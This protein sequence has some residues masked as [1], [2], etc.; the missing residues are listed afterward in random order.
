M[1]N[2][3]IKPILSVTAL[4]GIS[5]LSAQPQKPNVIFIYADDLG[6][7]LLSAYG[8]QQFTTPNIDSLVHRGTSFTRAYGCMV[9]AP[10]R[11]SLITGY[12]D[13]RTDKWKISGGGQFVD[14]RNEKDIQK[15]EKEIDK[16]DIV[17][18]KNDLYLPQVFQ[19]AGYVT[20]QIGKLE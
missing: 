4:L 9:S 5:S 15:I 12:H 16:N 19:Q 7:G 2:Q 10:A 13:C 11:A 1:K 20:A 3:I 18:P 6:K 8:Q 14:Y 17:L